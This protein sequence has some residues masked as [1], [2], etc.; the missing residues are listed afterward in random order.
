MR[1]KKIAH[2]T[3]AQIK[4]GFKTEKIALNENVNYKFIAK[5]KWLILAAKSEFRF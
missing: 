5:E 1:E 2:K 3:N 4:F